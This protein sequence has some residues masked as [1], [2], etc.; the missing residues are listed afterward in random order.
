MPEMEFMAEE[1]VTLDVAVRGGHRQASSLGTAEWNKFFMGQTFSADVARLFPDSHVLN[2]GPVGHSQSGHSGSAEAGVAVEAADPAA[3]DGP[4]PAA[5]H[6]QI[7]LAWRAAG[8]NYAETCRQAAAQGAVAVIIINAEDVTVPMGYAANEDAPPIP[9]AMIP[10][11]FGEELEKELADGEEAR[12]SLSIVNIVSSEQQEEEV[13]GMLTDKLVEDGIDESLLLRVKALQQELTQ[14]DRA[15][16]FAR[17]VK[18]QVEQCVAQCPVCLE[19]TNN[20]SSL[21]CVLPECFHTMCRSCL[22]R[23]AGAFHHRFLCPM[24]RMSVARI[25]VVTFRGRPTGSLPL[26]PLHGNPFPQP[27]DRLPATA[28]F[29]PPTGSPLPPP[30]RSPLPL[31]EGT[32]TATAAAA[33]AGGGGGEDRAASVGGA[34][35]VG[36]RAGDYLRLTKKLQQLVTLVQQLLAETNADGSEER[37]LVYTQWGAHVAHLSQVFEE[38]GIP[39]LDMMGTLAHTMDCLKR[40]GKP[41]QPRVLVLSSQRHA[42]GINLQVARNVV[43]VHPYCTPTATYPEAISTSMMRSYETQAV[44]RVRRFP[45]SKQVRVYRLFAQGTVE[46]ELYSGRWLH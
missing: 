3:G 1:R 39:V 33:A 46:E 35:G 25:D 24:C 13:E 10:K 29:T 42:S 18:A 16:V 43:F 17:E 36:E 34:Q 12:A 44:G 6:G 20:E 5:V 21:I 14:L 27:P 28:P 40:F 26:P 41:G 30:S 38:L 37:V 19:A 11:S 23:C 7:A 45:Q 15:L 32:P 22:E 2:G 9:C 4:V 8:R 31:E